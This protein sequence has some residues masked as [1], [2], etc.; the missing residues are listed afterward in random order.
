MMDSMKSLAH[1]L[2]FVVLPL[3]ACDDG[4]SASPTDAAASQADAVGTDAMLADV[5]LADAAAADAAVADAVADAAADAAPPDPYDDLEMWLCHPEKDGDPCDANLDSTVVHAD[6]STEVEPFVRAVDPPVDCFYVYPTV[7]LDPGIQADLPP[8]PEESYI[9]VAQA[10]RY[11]AVC[12]LYA[13]AYREVTV[14]ALIQGNRDFSVAYPDV[15][16][17]FEAFARRDPARPFLLIGH[18]Q[19]SSHLE[20]LL[21]EVIE[22]DDALQARLVSAHLIGWNLAIPANAD[23]GGAFERTPVCRTPQQTGCVVG[24]SAYRDTDPPGGNAVF[25]HVDEGRAVCAHPGALAGGS[26]F[27]R[28]Y[29]DSDI[30]AAL[31]TIA[32]EFAGPFADP[33]ASAAIATRFW[34]LPDFFEAECVTDGA[35][36]YL[37][38]RVHSDPDDPRVDDV[39]GDPIP[40]WG[41]HL[42]DVSLALGDLVALAGTQIA[43]FTE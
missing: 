22:A 20:R 37:Q 12:A 2:P 38:V 39:G 13:P 6:G 1:L 29:V 32:G 24:Y 21:R 28:P 15:L 36:S 7:S 17:A 42:V 11:Q 25:A 18:S 3:V 5:A 14:T 10:A 23:V 34:T 30:P 41:L 19:G 16:A 4:S 31:R 9:T 35:F 26:A 27:L 40:G 33:A 8:G 43:S